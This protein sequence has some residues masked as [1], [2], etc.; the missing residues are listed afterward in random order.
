M[1]IGELTRLFTRGGDSLFM[2]DW[3][4]CHDDCYLNGCFGSYRIK[5]PEWAHSSNGP[6]INGKPT[7]MASAKDAEYVRWL[8]VNKHRD[9]DNL[10]EEPG[11]KL[12]LEFQLTYLDQ[13]LEENWSSLEAAKERVSKIITD[14]EKLNAERYSAQQAFNNLRKD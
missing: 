9:F 1:N 4:V 6:H 2:S 10:E 3:H 8:L 7:K 14:R 13:R 11:E 5:M 12:S